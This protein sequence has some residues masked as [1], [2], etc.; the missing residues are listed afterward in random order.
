MAAT[1]DFL[2]FASATPG[3]SYSSV[4]NASDCRHA[5]T[6]KDGRMLTDNVGDMGVPV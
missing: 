5:T 3:P 6:L 4:R 2:T 1:E